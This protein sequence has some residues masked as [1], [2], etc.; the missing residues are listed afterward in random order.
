MGR[1]EEGG[2][3]MGNM[4]IPVADSFWYLA[5]LIQFVK[6]KNK[7]KLKK[8]RIRSSITVAT[9]FQHTPKGIQGGDQERD[10][11]LW[12]KLAEQA[13]TELVSEEFDEPNFLHHLISRK[14]LKSWMETSCS[15]WLAETFYRDVDLTAHTPLSRSYVYWP[16]HPSLQDNSSETFER[17]SPRL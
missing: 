15:S 8:K 1:E 10:T 13:F 17:L 7:I 9:D 4:C 5:K 16:P 11:V 6:F 12:E 2:F 3:R 14:A